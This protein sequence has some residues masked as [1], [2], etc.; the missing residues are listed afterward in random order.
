[1]SPRTR[2]VP[3]LAATLAV[4][5][6]SVASAPTA[7]ATID[8]DVQTISTGFSG[9]GIVAEAFTFDLDVAAPGGV[10]V[11]G[12]GITA[13]DQLVLGLFN[14]NLDIYTRS[15][16]AV[17]HEGSNTGW[18]KRRNITVQSRLAGQVIPVPVTFDL[19]TGRS[20]VRVVQTDASLLHYMIGSLEPLTASNG[21]LRLTGRSLTQNG[22]TYTDFG[23]FV[24]LDYELNLATT[25]TSGPSGLTNQNDP[26][27]TYGAVPAD[28]VDHFECELTPA[29]LGR[30]A[31]YG[32]CGN[33]SVSYLDLPDDDYTFSVRA[34]DDDGRSSPVAS[35]AFTVDTV[36]PDTSLESGPTG[37]STSTGAAFTYAGSGDVDHL[38]CDLSPAEPGG[39]AGY[40]TCDGTGVSYANL[41]DAAY[42]FS[43]RAVDAAGNADATPATGAFGVDTTA[44]DTLV[45]T[46]P[47]GTTGDNDPA[48]TYTGTDGD[49][50]R[51]ECDLA[52]AEPGG[53]AGFAPCANAGLAYTDLPEGGYTFSVRAVDALG[54]TDA[55][56]ATREF[57]VNTAAPSITAR[58]TS[59]LRRSASGW[60]R[61]PV[62]ITYT[63]DAG[64]STLAAPCPTSVTLSRSGARQTVTRWVRTAD[65]D[66][67]SSVTVVS[68]DRTGPQV[69]VAGFNTARIHS[70]RPAV[71]C[72]A[73][74]EL[75][76]VRSCRATVW[77]NA[78][79]T[80]VI[81]R[82]KAFDNAG[83]VRVRTLSARYNGR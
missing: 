36:A 27:F 50:D 35:R 64:G 70:R 37:I 48:F 83:N 28:K 25:V 69:R 66:A 3:A 23:P 54:N 32:T 38:E 5:G 53:T 80:R 46:G 58:V 77:F 9:G 79:R 47:S 10:R 26:V 63:C 72:V 22:T 14:L 56:P 67:V 34:V 30:P 39:A 78:A 24:S 68:I 41:P 8:D 43:V 17:G 45:S 62:T 4:I 29:D 21:D 20:A 82:A 55:T 81:V 11:R 44:P 74:D 71:R 52:P 12:L 7:A 18:T 61:A 1:M 49:V 40:E 16:S 6:L 42:T 31:G 15:G 51:F 59:P 13:S 57:L 73:T 76:G 19:P 33:G 75:S 65:G 2:L 60:Y